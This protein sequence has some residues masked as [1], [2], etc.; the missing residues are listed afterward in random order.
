MKAYLADGKKKLGVRQDVVTIIYV[1][2]T[3][4]EVDG[5]NCNEMSRGNLR[6]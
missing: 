5:R 6:N 1:E 3:L 2:A 4:S